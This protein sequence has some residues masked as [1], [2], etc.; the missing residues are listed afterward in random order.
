MGGWADHVI[1]S[2]VPGCWLAVPV[3]AVPRIRRRHAVIQAT[4]GFRTACPPVCSNLLSVC[5]SV[6]L[7]HP[8]F[9]VGVSWTSYDQQLLKLSRHAA[10]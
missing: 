9:V 1:E 2:A 8:C 4:S 7:S 3:V 6:C 5:P 10:R